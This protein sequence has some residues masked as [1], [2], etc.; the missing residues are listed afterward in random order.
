MT[1]LPPLR[2]IRNSW[3]WVSQ[4][5]KS[6]TKMYAPLLE[7]PV[8]WKDVRKDSF[9]WGEVGYR[10]F[11]EQDQLVYQYLTLCGDFYNTLLFC[12]LWSS[13]LVAV[14]F[15]ASSERDPS[16]WLLLPLCPVSNLHL[17]PPSATSNPGCLIVS[18]QTTS[19]VLCNDVHLLWYVRE[20]WVTCQSLINLL[21]IKCINLFFFLQ[22]W[23]SM[24]N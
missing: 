12:S 14:L 4:R 23:S 9:C 15:I 24:Y 22:R 2:V 18:W 16:R 13:L 5:P 17:P 20:Y 10:Y 21:C 7:F 1:I 19:G 8:G 11:M 6:L 3:G